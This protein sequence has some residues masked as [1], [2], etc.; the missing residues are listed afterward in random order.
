[1]RFDNR[2]A[3]R[4]GVQDLRDTVTDIVPYDIFDE[5]RSQR[6]TDDRSDEK[7]PRPSVGNELPFHQLLDEMDE[8][9]QDSGGTCGER[10][11]EKSQEKHQ[12]LLAD[13][14]FPPINNSLVP[15]CFQLFDVV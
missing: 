3:L 7:P 8:G 1:M 11:Y 12:M 5:Q 4:D 6:D 14:T 15:R 13:M 10:S 2:F 9:L